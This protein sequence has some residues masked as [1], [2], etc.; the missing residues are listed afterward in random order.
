MFFPKSCTLV[1]SMRMHSYTHNL[2][3][4]YSGGSLKD[5]VW[6]CFSNGG[7]FPAC[8]TM[9]LSCLLWCYHIW[10]VWYL[11]AKIYSSGWL[12]IYSL[13]LHLIKCFFQIKTK[14]TELINKNVK[15]KKH[16]KKLDIFHLRT[17]AFSSNLL[18]WHTRFSCPQ[19]VCCYYPELI[20]HPWN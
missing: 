9:F 7:K 2:T 4:R 3:D 16:I 15:I 18:W 5:T 10:A 8:I 20:F 6:F 19:S 13:D 12:K 17:S 1:P 11:L 14:I